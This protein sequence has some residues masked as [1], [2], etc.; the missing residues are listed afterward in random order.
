MARD[1]FLGPDHARQLVV[2][3]PYDAHDLPRAERRAGGRSYPGATDL[4]ETRPARS[5]V[6]VGI[7]HIVNRSYS[8]DKLARSLCGATGIVIHSAAD[9]EVA[10]P[11]SHN[12]GAAVEKSPVD[13]RAIGFRE[14]HDFPARVHGRAK[15]LAPGQSANAQEP[16]PGAARETIHQGGASAGENGANHAPRVISRAARPRYC[17]G[18]DVSKGAP[19]GAVVEGPSQTTAGVSRNAEH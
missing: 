13:S 5:V 7:K 12:P 2:Y 1:A 9:S 6:N 8:A 17:R 18:R 15:W 19:G 14:A 3:A 4:G 16:L 10:R 11:V